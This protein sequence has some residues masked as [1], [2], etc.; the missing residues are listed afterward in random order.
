MTWGEVNLDD[1]LWIVPAQ[2][3]KSGVPHEV[4]LSGMTMDLLQSLPRAVLVENEL[5]GPIWRLAPPKRRFVSFLQVGKTILE[6]G[7]EGAL[8]QT[9]KISCLGKGGFS[10]AC[11]SSRISAS[12]RTRWRGAISLTRSGILKEVAALRAAACQAF[13]A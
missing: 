1:A 7:L 11:H 3:T 8:L 6:D 10:V 12:L 9:T 13:A 4:P 2:R 5:I